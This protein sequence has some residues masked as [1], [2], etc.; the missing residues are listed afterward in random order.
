MVVEKATE[1][2]LRDRTGNEDVL[3]DVK[4]EVKYGGI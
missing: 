4:V 2:T 3:K 1:E